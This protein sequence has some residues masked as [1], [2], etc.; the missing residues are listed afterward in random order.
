MYYNSFGKFD[1]IATED[2]NTPI[3]KPAELH[4]DITNSSSSPTDSEAKQ[5][6]T[7]DRQ[8]DMGIIEQI[9]RA[10]FD[11]INKM[12]Q[13]YGAMIDALGTTA[14]KSFIDEYTKKKRNYKPSVPMKVTTYRCNTEPAERALLNMRAFVEASIKIMNSSVYGS[15]LDSNSVLE[16]DDA[17]FVKTVLKKVNAPDKCKTFEEYLTY[18]RSV[19][20]GEKQVVNITDDD[21]PGYEKIALLRGDA[22][23]VKLRT[24]RSNCND[25]ITK[26]RNN[27][28]LVSSSKSIQNKEIINRAKKY[29][30]RMEKIASYYNN[31]LDAYM[32]IKINKIN[33]AR[34]VLSSVYEIKK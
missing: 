26:V 22:L 19:C 18:L 29:S 32:S 11:M 12:F 8:E 7:K 14:E 15:K 16:M 20:K 2:A 27:L 6:N 1:R 24:D 34:A 5:Y 31:F 30:R 9:V 25:L 3:A 33:V 10:L 23:K 21:L 17:T 13:R 4:E 28:K